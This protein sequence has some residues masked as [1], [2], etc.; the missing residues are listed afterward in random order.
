MFLLVLVILFVSNLT[1]SY[2]QLE[3]ADEFDQDTLDATN[4]EVDQSDKD[5]CDSKLGLDK[6]LYS[7]PCNNI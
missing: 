5:K 2:W 6:H 7:S 3:W 1:S 4:W